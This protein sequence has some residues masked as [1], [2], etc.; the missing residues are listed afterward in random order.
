M[1]SPQPWSR[2]WSLLL[3]GFCH[4]QEVADA[5]GDGY[6]WGGT[7]LT[8]LLGQRQRLRILDICH[9]VLDDA[10]LYATIKECSVPPTAVAATSS[11]ARAAEG[12]KMKVESAAT[13]LGPQSL[14]DVTRF[15]LAFGEA[16]AKID[17]VHCIVRLCDPSLAGV[18]FRPAGETLCADAE[19]EPPPFDFD[20]VLGQE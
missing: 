9:Q 18:E 7:V 16:G 2:L 15:A 8:F 4:Y 11:F 17:S 12:L 6:L 20:D 10:M 14:E 19:F 13:M 1:M 5:H 3:F